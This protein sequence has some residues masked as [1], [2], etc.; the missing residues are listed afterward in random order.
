[1]SI[2]SI[3]HNVAH[4]C[5]D[6]LFCDNTLLPAK[7]PTRIDLELPNFSIPPEYEP[8]NVEEYFAGLSTR[9]IRI[10]NDHDYDFNDY[11][12]CSYC[13]DLCRNDT[14]FCHECKSIMCNYCY[15]EKL[16]DN[17]STCFQHVEQIKLM[18]E[19][20]RCNNCEISSKIRDGLWLCDRENDTDYCPNCQKESRPGI[21]I[22]YDLEPNLVKFGS[23]LDWIPLYRHRDGHYV[24][25]NVNQDSPSYHKLALGCVDK[26]GLEGVFVTDYSLTEIYDL[27]NKSTIPDVLQKLGHEIYYG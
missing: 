16:K 13:K 24:L 27:C 10:L 17:R 14:R 26:K 19:P 11:D 12:E 5:T 23:Y 4:T 9:Y 21:P 7:V 20:V 22:K 15:E 6:Y 3:L 2:E 1:M 8:W 18:P 25:Y